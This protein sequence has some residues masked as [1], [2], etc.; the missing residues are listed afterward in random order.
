MKIKDDF[1]KKTTKACLSSGTWI[2]SSFKCKIPT[3]QEDS[4][5]L[6]WW[7]I[8]RIEMEDVECTPKNSHTTKFVKAWVAFSA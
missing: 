3:I 1:I 8:G 7:K 6:L 4:L 5:H 2:F